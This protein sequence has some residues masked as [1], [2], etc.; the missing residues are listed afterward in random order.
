MAFTNLN[1]GFQSVAPSNLAPIY[2]GN[3]WFTGPPVPNI[4]EDTKSLLIAQGWDIVS[5]VKNPVHPHETTYTM[6]RTRLLSWNV[7]QSLLSDFTFA[8]NE[9]REA[10]QR[11][12]EDVIDGYYEMLMKFQTETDAFQVSKANGHLLYMLVKMDSLGNE[13][14][15]LQ[16]DIAAIDNGDRQAALA[17]LKANWEA[18]ANSADAEYGTMVSGLNLP[19]I[20]A[21]VDAAMTNFS[22]AVAAFNVNY[23]GLS[24]LLAS[25]F[26]THQSLT[27]GLLTGLGATELARINEKYGSSLATQKQ[28]LVDRGFYSSSIVTDITARNTR[29][30]NEAVTELN[31][32]LNR[33]KLANEHTLYGQQYQMRLGGLDAS[34]KALDAAARVVQMRLQHGQWTSSIRHGVAQISVN[35][36]L[37][38]LGLRERYYRTL[39]DTVGWESDQRFRL[40]DKLIEVHLKQFELRNRVF[41]KDFELMKYQLDERSNIAGAL[42]GFVE[43]RTDD[44]PDMESIAQLTAALGETG[45]STWHAP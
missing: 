43:R 2:M 11:R 44:Y 30:K 38:L 33:E 1:P 16:N 42:F 34:M 19:S 7:L 15:D 21:G 18:A 3:W 29:E 31:D 17:Q 4:S 26:T 6:Q 12:Y 45:A 24:A 25:D 35:A 10:N 40:H 5:S 9:G 39:M 14:I 23:A 20:I 41:D 27:R 37:A 32:K 28:Q 22:S 8:F 36:R 13:A